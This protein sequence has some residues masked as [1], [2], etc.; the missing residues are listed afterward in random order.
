MDW[1]L[2]PEFLFCEKHEGED[3]IIVVHTQR[4]RFLV[5]FVPGGET[6][7]QIDEATPEELAPAR[8]RACAFFEGEASIPSTPLWC[9]LDYQEYPPG[10]TLLWTSDGQVVRRGTWTDPEPPSSME[11]GSWEDEQGQPIGV[12]HWM[13]LDDSAHSPPPLPIPK[14]RAHGGI[15]AFRTREGSPNSEPLQ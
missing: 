3:R 11:E 4:P 13:F 10:C 8:P 6:L 2:L 15:V 12:T 7:Y 1:S 5:A 9:R 14:P